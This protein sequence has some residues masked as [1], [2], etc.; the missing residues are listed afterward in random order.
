MNDFETYSAVK[1]QMDRM[2]SN[3][4]PF[5][6]TPFSGMRMLDYN[7]FSGSSIT[8]FNPKRGDG[9]EPVTFDNVNDLTVFLDGYLLGLHE[10]A[11]I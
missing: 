2:E 6:L 3:C 9:T 4:I 7:R 1:T 11:T 5:Y 8:L 10:M